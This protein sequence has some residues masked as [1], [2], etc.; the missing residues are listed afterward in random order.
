M[1]GF[2]CCFGGAAGPAQKEVA[3]VPAAKAATYAAPGASAAPAASGNSV[4]QTATSATTQATGVAQNAPVPPVVSSR[5]LV[6]R[7]RGRVELPAFLKA[8]LNETAWIS[9]NRVLGMIRLN[10]GRASP[11][12]SA[13][14]LSTGGPAP[15]RGLG[16]AYVIGLT[17]ESSMTAGSV[18][19]TRRVG[20][21]HWTVKLMSDARLQV[22]HLQRQLAA[23]QGTWLTRVEMALKLTMECTGATA[24]G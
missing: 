22:L 4:R 15:S 10:P 19:R 8:Y 7:T 5:H 20:S 12:T 23:L 17:V 1:P 14:S 13:K 9:C 21:R 11:I 24:V 3:A 6:T 16:V 2:L 18:R